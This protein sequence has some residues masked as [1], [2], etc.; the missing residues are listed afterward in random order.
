MDIKR[1]GVIGVAGLTTAAVGAWTFGAFDG[2][3][4]P[5]ARARH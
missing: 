1:A 4:E 3:D 5:T 2:A